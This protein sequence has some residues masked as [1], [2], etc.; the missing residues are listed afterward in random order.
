VNQLS[1]YELLEP[2][3]RGGYGTVYHARETVLDV[4]RAIKVLHP[5][6][7]ADP[8]FI[9][10]FRKEARIAARLEH[11][12]IV[13]VYELDEAQGNYF[14]VMKYMP[15]G[16][17]K[18]LLAKQGH[19]PFERAVEI[20]RQVAEAL[21]YAYNRPEKLIHCDL[22]PGN[23]L[24]DE[25]GSVCLADFGFAKALAEASLSGSTGSGGVIGTPHYIPPEV[26]RGKPVS[27]A[28]DV[29]SL[30]CVFY[31]MLTGKTLFPGESPAELVTRHVVDGP[32]FPEQWP[33]DVM[34][35]IQAVLSKALARDPSER[36]ASVEAFT[37][38][39]ADLTPQSQLLPGPA[40][41]R[42]YSIATPLI[43]IAVTLI[44][45]LFARR[46]APVPALITKTVVTTVAV[47]QVGQ[48]ATISSPTTIPPTQP[49][50]TKTLPPTNI[51]NLDIPP[52]CI[53]TGQ[54]WAS[55]VDNMLMVCVPSGDFLMGSADNDPQAA[56]DEKPQHQVYLDAFWID[57]TEVT[58]AMFERFVSATG[59]QTEAEN[60]GTGLV[61]DFKLGIWKAAQGANWR[62]P[63][64]PTSDISGLG[65][66]PV[67]QMSWNDAM[68]Y[69]QWAGRRLPTEAE[70]EKAARG[71][72][73]RIYPW[74]NQGVAGNLLNFAD[75]K[76][77]MDWADKNVDDGFQFTS[78]VGNYPAGASPYGVKDIAGNA[79]EWVLDWYGE[80]YY[81]N[82]PLENPKG[83][84]SGYF[85][86]W[87]G[88]SWVNTI[89]NVR[90]T[91]RSKSYPNNR[92]D[93]IGFRCAY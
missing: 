72:D 66:H 54:A 75:V 1:K 6:L 59:F 36:Y 16:S 29:Y 46:P 23:I 5:P 84:S 33:T 52:A 26:W 37:Q 21:D 64:G 15:G 88:G 41:S 42:L 68:A 50:P 43:I 25:D 2:I 56:G 79:W 58:N 70:W 34:E 76:L 4:E 38:A 89:I 32:Q 85:R 87:R 67:V 91:N 90:A 74:G 31:E 78:P 17:L 83:P 61:L 62:H 45:I 10:R 18:D 49:L 22:K 77:K 51:L 53:S 19:L 93:Y 27:P 81:Q 40:K 11:P 92:E 86:I 39:L 80:D 57:Q 55:P 13:P 28:T 20:T 60:R 9:E 71:S 44:I 12:H 47:A 35:G 3:G 14:L 69:C 73:A 63:R 8:V 7:A 82:S 48:L 65:D 24:F 30:A